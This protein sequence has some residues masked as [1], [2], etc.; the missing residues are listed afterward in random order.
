[1]GA[2]ITFTLYDENDEPRE[3]YSRGFVPWGILKAALKLQSL[4]K[5]NLTDED[6]DRINSLVVAFYG[7]KF[8]VQDLENGA[9]LQETLAVLMAI[10]SRLEGDLPGFGGANPT[11]PGRAKVKKPKTAT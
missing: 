8:S 9:S 10:M 1:M 5:D 2:P 4:D 7:N 11:L 3:S 6:I